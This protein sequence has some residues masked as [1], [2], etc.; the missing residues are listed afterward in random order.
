MAGEEAWTGAKAKK[1]FDLWRE[2]MPYYQKGAPG[3]TWEEAGQGLKRRRTGMAV[4]GMPHPGQQ[5][6]ENERDD[7]DFFAFP[8]IDPEHGQDAVEEP[9]DGFLNSRESQ[10]QGRGKGSPD[11][12]Q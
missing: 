5:F 9:I 4:F 12:A 11:V 8:E 2:P 1:V 3:R 7:I 10:E 6:P